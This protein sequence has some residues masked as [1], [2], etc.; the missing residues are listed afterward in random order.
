M[1]LPATVS[2]FSEVTL[3]GRSLHLAIGMFDGVHLGHQAVIESAIHSARRSGGVSAVLTFW[4]HPSHILRASEPTLLLMTA[5]TKAQVLHDLGV[6]LIIRKEFTREF[7][8]IEAGDF[9]THLH[10]EL[11]SLAAIYVGENFR[12]GKGRTGDLA[13]LIADAE[14]HGINVYS[15]PRI[16]RNGLDISSTR[17][18]K[19]L[20]EGR[21]EDVNA[22]LGYT[23]FSQGTVA[24]GREMGRKL[25]FP[26]LNFAWEPEFQPCYGVYAVK[27]IPQGSTRKLPG[28]ANYGVRP[29]LTDD[30][31]PVLEVH[32]LGSTDM[33]PGDS[34]TVEWHTFLRPEMKFNGPDALKAQIEE[35]RNKAEA[36]F[37]SP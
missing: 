32:V 36:Y 6:D 23:Y 25:G 22:L 20:A 24:R 9:V 18:R 33:G 10:K 30:A 29:T 17:I 11:P 14:K 8:A 15:A 16:K 2:D 19:D 27:I 7:A 5:G 4:P 12:F 26:T 21:M 34:A 13:L 31:E 35:D 3:D 28:V 37:S 1:N